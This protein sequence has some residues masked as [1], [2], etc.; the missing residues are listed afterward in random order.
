ALRERSAARP[1]VQVARMTAVEFFKLLAELLKTSPPHPID[2]VM[3][4]QLAKLGIKPGQSFQAETLGV[5]LLKALEEGAQSAL[6]FLDSCKKNVTVAETG[7]PL[8]QRTGRYGTPYVPRAL[9][10]LYLLGANP[11]KAAVYFGCLQDASE[12]LLTGS[13][14]SL[15]HF[16]K[17]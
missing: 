11:P 12:K 4:E 14:R 9:T 5:E 17:S 13:A 16:K 2:G 10:A 6:A 7:W 15:M 1:P 3:M 8:P